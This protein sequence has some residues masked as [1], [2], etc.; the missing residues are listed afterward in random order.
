MMPEMFGAYRG[1]VADQPEAVQV[2][3]CTK[4]HCPAGCW[5]PKEANRAKDGAALR[6]SARLVQ[7]ICRIKPAA[8]SF[9]LCI[10]SIVLFPGAKRLWYRLNRGGDRA[11]N[12]AI[13]TP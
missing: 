2:A 11:L 10:R 6:T 7:A 4:A 9:P 12:C 13:H 8:L 5:S 1:A 3:A